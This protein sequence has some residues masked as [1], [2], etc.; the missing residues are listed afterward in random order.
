MAIDK[1]NEGLVAQAD[2]VV[3]EEGKRSEA[4]FCHAAATWFYGS[5]QRHHAASAL[6]PPGPGLGYVSE[7]PIGRACILLPRCTPVLEPEKQ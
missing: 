7:S 1:I 4:R 6:P 2:G 3:D 5:G